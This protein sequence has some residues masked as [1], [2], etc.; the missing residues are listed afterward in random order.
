ML[1]GV[2]VFYGVPYL[3]AVETVVG[4]A[5]IVLIL[6]ENVHRESGQEGTLKQET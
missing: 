1:M 2:G 6:G 3:G 5:I 4:A